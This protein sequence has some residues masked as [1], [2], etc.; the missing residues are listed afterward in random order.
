MVRDHWDLLVHDVDRDLL[1][2]KLGREMTV[3]AHMQD[4]YRRLGKA[5]AR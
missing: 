2:L 3:V 4:G 1:M 5:S